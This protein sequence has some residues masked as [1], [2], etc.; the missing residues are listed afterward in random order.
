LC[1]PTAQHAYWQAR[2]LGGNIAA[3]LRGGTRSYRHTSAGSVASLG[4]YRGVAEVH[5]LHGSR[6]DL[7]TGR[8]LSPPA[9]R[10][11]AVFAV[12]TDGENVFVRLGDGGCQ[13]AG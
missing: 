2:R 11:V 3:A 5:G 12:R 6:F 8:V 13:S 4:L 7:T 9:T 10:P 1:A